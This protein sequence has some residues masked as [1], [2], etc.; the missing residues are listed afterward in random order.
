MPHIRIRAM[1]DS[2]VKH[3]S[4]KL[5]AEL[6]KVLNTTADSFTVEKVATEFYFNGSV[7]QGDPM[8]EV[9][10]FDRGQ[11]LKMACATKI[12]ELARQHTTAEY[13]AVIFI[14]LAKNSYF[15]NGQHF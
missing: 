2:D 1:S 11:E 6:A 5:P 15:E 12:T 4:S 14:D 8:I 3:L 7:V 10:W 9:L 13:L